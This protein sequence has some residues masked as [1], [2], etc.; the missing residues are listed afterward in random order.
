MSIGHGNQPE[1][2]RAIRAHANFAE[3]VP[4]TLLL[5]AMFETLSQSVIIVHLLG[6]AILAAR[7]LHAYSINQLQEVIRHRVIAMLT[8]F[9]VM[10]TAS[11]GI[12]VTVLLKQ[13]S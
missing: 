9:A 4:F 12:L 1:L 5:L 11:G 8:T 6:L 10:A 7:L 2:E 13:L 3:Y